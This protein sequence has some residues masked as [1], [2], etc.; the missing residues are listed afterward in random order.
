MCSTL[1]VP[2]Q[3]G[4]KPLRVMNYDINVRE[5]QAL[6]HRGSMCYI[7]RLTEAGPETQEVACVTYVG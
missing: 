4:H 1:T 7:R 5:E 3:L 6:R 2:L